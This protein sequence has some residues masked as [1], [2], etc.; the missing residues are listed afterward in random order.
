[1]AQMTGIRIEGGFL[2]VMHKTQKQAGFGVLPSPCDSFAMRGNNLH[3]TRCPKP[4]FPSE[5]LRCCSSSACPHG[6]PL[7][8]TVSRCHT[9][10]PSRPL[11]PWGARWLRSFAVSCTASAAWTASSPYVQANRDVRVL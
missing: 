1:M 3:L 10:R 7:L 4:A 11:L 9:R 6:A 2:G 8:L 5:Q